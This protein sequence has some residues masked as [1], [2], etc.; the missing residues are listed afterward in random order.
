[1]EELLGTTVIE[2]PFLVPSRDWVE[3][4]V[5]IFRRDGRLREME[6]EIERKDGRLLVALASAEAVVVGGRSCALVSLVDVTERRNAETRLRHSQKL[7]AIGQLAGGLADDFNNLL[8]VIN[9]Y[10]DRMGASVGEGHPL[11]QDLDLI[12]R[13]GQRAAALTRQLLAF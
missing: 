8:T 4:A 12:Q 5:G 13:A 2:L 6:V 10:C 7:E 11:R 1:R 9:G 3:K